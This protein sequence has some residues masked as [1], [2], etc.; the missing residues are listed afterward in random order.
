MRC[1]NILTTGPG[2]AVWSQGVDHPSHIVGE[3]RMTKKEF[4]KPMLVEENSLAELTLQGVT[5]GAVV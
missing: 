4:R 1:R 2:N 3:L 5:S